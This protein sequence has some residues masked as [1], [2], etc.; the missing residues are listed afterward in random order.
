MAQKIYVDV[1]DTLVIWEYPSYINQDLV[2]VLQKGMNAGLIDITI[3]SGTGQPWA[4]KY[5]KFLF[6]E[7]NLETYSKDEKYDKIPSGSFAIDDRLQ[8][9]R[10]YLEGFDKVFLPA[11]FVKYMSEWLNETCRRC[12]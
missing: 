11:D 1:D 3:W 6:S 2:E 7:Y 5:S 8:E 12:S 10:K 4:E 9:E